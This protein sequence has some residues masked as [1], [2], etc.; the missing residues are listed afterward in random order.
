MP[1]VCLPVC[2]VCLSLCVLAKTNEP[3][4]VKILPLLYVWTRQNRLNFG[5]HTPP[6]RI[7]EF[8]QGLFNIARLAFTVWLIFPEKNS[9]IFTNFLP[10]TVGLHVYVF[11]QMCPC[12]KMFQLNCRG[13]PN[14]QF[15]SDSPWRG[16]MCSPNAVVD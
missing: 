1:G 8:F 10:Y 2:S 13:D 14:F 7:Q 16:Y 15:G 9:G 4:F 6:D 3:I 12:T 5:S 11:L